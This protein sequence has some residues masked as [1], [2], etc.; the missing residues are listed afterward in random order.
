MDQIRKEERHNRVGKNR[1][2]RYAVGMPILLGVYLILLLFY[3]YPHWPVDLFGWLIL[4]L[5]G[6]PISLFLEWIGEALLSQ[7]TGSTLSGKKFSFKRI[8]LA[9]LLF[10]IIGCTLAFLWFLFSPFLRQH[11][12]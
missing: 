9:L 11:F 3:S 8:I 5:G 2:R 1:L 10:I 6:V 12:A 7:N 4:I